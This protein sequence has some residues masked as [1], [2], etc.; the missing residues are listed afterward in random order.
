[1]NFMFCMN[2]EPEQLSFLPEIARLGAGIELGSPNKTGKRA[3][4]C[5]KQSEL[6]SRGLLPYMALSLAWNM[7]TS[8]T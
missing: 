6:N 2:G 5:T 8:T 3:S 7:P 4:H 1:M